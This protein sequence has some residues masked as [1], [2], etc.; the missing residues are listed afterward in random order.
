MYGLLNR[1]HSVGPLVQGNSCTAMQIGG[2]ESFLQPMYFSIVLL[3]RFQY[4]LLVASPL[5]LF[6]SYFGAYSRTL[7]LLDA[8]FG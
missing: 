8:T 4:Y 1:G 7:F 3:G 2:F 5:N 6:L